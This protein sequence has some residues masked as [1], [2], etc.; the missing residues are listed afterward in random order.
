MHKYKY[1][2]FDSDRT[3]LDFDAAQRE[4]VNKTFVK[5]NIPADEEAHSFYVSWNNTLWARLEKGEIT[6]DELLHMRFPVVCSRYG[7]AY[8]GYGKIETD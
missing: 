2:L 8:P 3:L 5:Y 6:H 7:V 4:A 1:L